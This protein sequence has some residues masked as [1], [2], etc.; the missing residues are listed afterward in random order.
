MARGRIVRSF[1]KGRSARTED[2]MAVE[3]RMSSRGITRRILFLLSVLA[4]SLGGTALRAHEIMYKG[5][6]ESAAAGRYA[7]PDGSVK[8]VPELHVRVI[9][10]RSKK[11]V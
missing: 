1:L 6:V 9:E 11:P 5:T 2:I 4:L 7:Q 3:V 8:E 10:E